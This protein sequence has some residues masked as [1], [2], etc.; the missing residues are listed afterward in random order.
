MLAAVLGTA[1]LP[2]PFNAGASAQV[3]TSPVGL[4]P[5]DSTT[6][7]V[8]SSAAVLAA[9]VRDEPQLPR[10]AG[11]TPTTPPTTRPAQTTTTTTL[12]PPTTVPDNPADDLLGGLGFGRGFLQP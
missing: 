2:S 5:D 12:V 1:G 11:P 8:P 4:S 6:T 9:E 10:T 7:T 3:R